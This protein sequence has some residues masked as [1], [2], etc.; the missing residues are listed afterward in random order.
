MSGHAD[1]TNIILTNPR[2]IRVPTIAGTRESLRGL[3]KIVTDFDKERVINVTWPKT[4]GRMVQ[5]GTGDQAAPTEGEFV[6]N[7][8]LRLVEVTNTAVRDGDYTTGMALNPGGQIWVREANYHPCG[9]QIVFPSVPSADSFY[10]VLLGPPG[11]DV[12][13][14]QFRCFRI[15]GNIGIQILPGVWHQ[16][17]YPSQIG[18]TRFRNKQCSVH[19][20]VVMDTILERN[21]VFAIDIGPSSKL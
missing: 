15:P 6:V 19:A 8:Q 9:G 5:P 20:C 7:R 13:H 21:L 12:D 3:A 10:Y 11:D 18:E 1:Y 4:R 17:V 16:P 14:T 2:E